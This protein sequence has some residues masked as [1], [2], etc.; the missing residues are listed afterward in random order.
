MER[1]Y[2]YLLLA[3][4]LFVIS[5]FTGVEFFISENDYAGTR[6]VEFI[7]ATF[8]SLLYCLGH[9]ISAQIEEKKERI[10]E[11]HKSTLT[12]ALSVFTLTFF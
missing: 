10:R 9:Y 12:L 7:V 4:I 8:V 5:I 6:F 2:I 3:G 11:E 1:F